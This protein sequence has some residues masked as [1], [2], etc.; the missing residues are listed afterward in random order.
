LYQNTIFTPQNPNMYCVGQAGVCA[1]CGVVIKV[2]RHLF[3][4]RLLN[5]ENNSVILNIITKLGNGTF[6]TAGK[7]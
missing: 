4:G 6:S 7:K 1:M 2:T 3:K 5:V